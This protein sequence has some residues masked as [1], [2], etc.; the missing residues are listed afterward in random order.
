M[1]NTYIIEAAAHNAI[2]RDQIESRN[3]WNAKINFIF[4]YAHLGASLFNVRI[5][6]EIK[7]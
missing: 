3:A 7:N 1:K 4:R 2:V 6:K 5:I